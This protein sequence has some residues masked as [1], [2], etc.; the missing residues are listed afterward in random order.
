M[1]Y[2]MVDVHCEVSGNSEQ[3]ER[4]ASMSQEVVSKQKPMTR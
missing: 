4:K 1:N 3:K 2:A